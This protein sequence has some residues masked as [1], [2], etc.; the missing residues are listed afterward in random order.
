[1]NPLML[2]LIPHLLWAT[3]VI[4]ALTLAA[5][6]YVQKA[7]VEVAF[8]SYQKT[9]AQ[10]KQKLQQEQLAKLEEAQKGVERIAYEDD[11]KRQALAARAVRAESAAASLRDE[12][13]R[14]NARPAPEDAGAAAY[15]RE[16]STA[17]ELLGECSTRRTEVARAADELREQ[18]TGLQDFAKNVCK[19]GQ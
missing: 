6:I 13:A 3:G 15:A 9:T 7:R 17:R 1:M 14:L 4:A 16:A 19:A 18:V 11:K 12:V 2:R 10:E 8:S 5:L